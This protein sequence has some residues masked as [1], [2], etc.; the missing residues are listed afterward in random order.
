MSTPQHVALYK[1]FRVML[2]LPSWHH[3]KTAPCQ[4][5]TMSRQHHVKTA[6]VST[7]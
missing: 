6:V 3:V 7:R 4:D 5:G 1:V 2:E